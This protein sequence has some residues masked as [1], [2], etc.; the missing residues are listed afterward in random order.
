MV[1]VADDINISAD[2]SDAI[3]E[4]RKLQS[5]VVSSMQAAGA[6]TKELNSINKG[7]EGTFSRVAAAAVNSAQKTSSALKKEVSETKA[8]IS[9]AEALAKARAKAFEEVGVKQNK[10]GQLV[11]STTGRFASAAQKAKVEEIALTERLR[12][13]E[14][15]LETQRNKSAQAELKRSAQYKLGEEMAREVNRQRM[16]Q[17][18]TS[19]SSLVGLANPDATKLQKFANVLSQIPPATWDAKMRGAAERFMGMG[20]SAR[21]ALYEV[22]NSATIAGAAIFSF[23]ALAVTAAIAHERA[24]ANV[25]RTTQTT[26]AGYE[27]LRRQL[28][29]MSMELP[30]TYDELTKIASAAGQLGIGA[31]GV[32][33]F[34]HVVAQLTATTNL[35]SDAA[36]I[37]LARF[38]TFFSEV[39]G[40]NGSQALAVTDATFTNLASSIL[41]VGVNSIASES[42][43]VNVA[44]Q[45]AS[46]GEYAGLTANQVIGLA[47]A[48]S[49]IGVAP[50]LSRGTITRTFSLIGNAV[51]ENGVKLEQFADLAGISS[52]QFKEAWGT[53]DFAQVF[54][55]LMGGIK[56]I[57][58]E[59]G[60]ANLALQELGFNSVRDRPLLLRLAG[61]ADEAGIKG[62]LLAQTLRDAYSG[63]TQNSELALQYSKISRTAS[64]R[65][66]VLGQSFEQLAA[67]MGKQTGGFLGEMAVQLTGVIRGF[68]EF[69]QSDFGQVLGTIAVQGAIAAGALLLMVGGAA[70]AAASTQAIGTAWTEMRT[71]VDTASNSVSRF[72]AAFRVMQASLGIIGMVATVAALVGGMIAMNDAATK[73]KRGV[74]DVGGL[75]AAMAV[76]AES[77]ADGVTFW[78]QANDGATMSARN[79]ADQAKDMTEAL[80]GVSASAAMGAEQMQGIADASERA[81]YVFGDTAK[82]FYRSQL[83]QS[84]TFQS[85]FDP[86]KAL[87]SIGSNYQDLGLDKVNINWDKL[88]K[89]S[90]KDGG[91]NKEELLQDLMDQTG[92]ERFGQNGEFSEGFIGLQ[93]QVDTIADSYGQLAPEIQKTINANA[94]LQ[95]QGAETFAEIYDGADAATQSVGELDE[96]TQKMV[97]GIAAGFA[98]FADVGTL[99]GLA[100]QKAGISSAEDPAKAAADF[101]TAWMNAYGGASFA[102]EDYLSV[103]RDAGGE[104]KSFIEDLSVLRERASSLGIDP[105]F[106]NDLAAMGPEANRLVEALVSGTDDQ[107]V[108]FE[109]LWGQS[110]YDSMVLFATQAAIGQE[111]VNAVMRAGGEENGLAY[112]QKFNE[113][114]ASGVGV[115]QALAELQLDVNGKPI[116]PAVSKPKVPN[117]TWAEK[118][119][120]AEQNR[121]QTTARVKFVGSAIVRSNPTT[122]GHSIENTGFAGGGWTG[123]GGKYDPKGVVHGD[124]FVFTKEATRAIGVG[125]LYAMMNAA[126]GGRAAP[127]GKGYAQGGMVSGGGNGYMELSPTDRALLRQLG[128]LRVMIG[129]RDIQQGLATA[130]FSTGRQG[131]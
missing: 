42:G 56:G 89:D 112:L 68:E 86:S 14:S 15:S 40:G 45:I 78:S 76:D 64:A 10:T 79:A 82:E 16:T 29:V 39:N 107:L 80:Y 34:T 100:Q 83:A 67:S 87:N 60:D 43:I 61:A 92:I 12:L 85:L 50:E 74:Q 17:S 62:G 124:E 5:A 41:K 120:W 94:A 59:G 13:A 58:D 24:F 99:I 104:Q 1:T 91:I 47:G 30:I 101:E 122:G 4:M 103:Y 49:S 31:S 3:A 66:Q 119:I 73:A 32:A 7:L 116:K 71:G 110:G 81:K 106:L 125:N 54:T 38:R 55:D 46:M 57:S 121:L 108:E 98:K 11:D 117:M 130:N 77:G 48:L 25:E 6:S 21:Y 28:E 27:V 127:R 97:D 53:Q 96:A 2:A 118:Q 95:T 93:K 102:L 114:L 111:V 37:A 26:A 44:V 19:G 75:I 69:S 51:S 126:Q 131:Y 113:L 20:N 115:D 8:A 22:A 109:N 90:L 105:A 23:G 63:W 52:D 9:A 88:M 65:I 128:Q 33:A 123:S 129:T 70:R 35:T 18:F 36:G 84:E 72:G